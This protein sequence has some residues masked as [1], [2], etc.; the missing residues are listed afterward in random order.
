MNSKFD[1]QLSLSSSDPGSPLT[2]V[3]AQPH[4]YEFGAKSFEDELIEIKGVEW[5]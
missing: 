1:N 5:T 3:F 4:N 2:R